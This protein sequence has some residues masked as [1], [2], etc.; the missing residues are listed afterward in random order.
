M[1]SVK[2]TTGEEIEAD[3]FVACAGIQPNVAIA[4]A[5][6]LKVNRGVIVDEM[7]R[8][9]DP[10]VFAIG[11]VAELP[12]AVGGL[13]AVSTAQAT[14]AVTTM[15]GCETRYVPPSTLVSLKMDGIDVKEFPG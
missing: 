13:W 5:A 6:G 11:D 1:R 4:R 15:L 14:A 12:G 7:L 3:I 10:N 8:T 9:S 2:L